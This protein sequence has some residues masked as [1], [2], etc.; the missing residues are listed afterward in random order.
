MSKVAPGGGVD[1]D[2][3]DN[4]DSIPSISTEEDEEEEEEEDQDD[5]GAAMRG[6]Q[7]KTL[8]GRRGAA[9]DAEARDVLNAWKERPEPREHKD[10]T[11]YKYPCYNLRWF[12]GCCIRYPIEDTVVLGDIELVI[13]T[14]KRVKRRFP[15][16]WRARMNVRHEKYGGHTLTSLAILEGRQDIAEWLIE[17]G[18]DID[19]RDKGSGLAPLHHAVRQECLTDKF[20]PIVE[21]LIEAGAEID[22]RDKRGAT[23]LML[24]CLFG[25]LDVVKLLLVHHAD[26]E[27]R[28]KEGWRPI[29]YASYGGRIDAAKVLVVEEG[30]SI[31]IKDKRRKISEQLVSYMFEF[32][33]ARQRHGAVV[34]FLD[35][36]V[37]TVT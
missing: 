13:S 34:S 25:N 5:G 26:L 28:D 7:E 14:A 18:L 32:E 37:P 21:A 8:G 33:G 16:D 22:I 20:K 17:N 10:Y 12:M 19:Q 31:D 24:A 36:Y 35:A 23:P 11:D 3:D 30:A 6:D 4:S 15:D 2:D 27:A 29:N 9:R 1:D